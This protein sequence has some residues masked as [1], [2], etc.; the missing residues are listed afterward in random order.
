M[1]SLI[2]KAL[3]T[4]LLAFAVSVIAPSTASAD[5]N[6]FMFANDN[7]Y[8]GDRVIAGGGSWELTLF[9]Y[10]TPT[11]Y[12]VQNPGP[13]N[14][15]GNSNLGYCWGGYGAYS[16]HAVMQ[17]DGNFV[18]Y[19]GSTAIWSTGTH[20]WYGSYLN[21]Q[22]DSNIVVYTSWDYPLWSIW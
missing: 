8:C 1:C 22:D 17:G 18:A 15:C 5:Y 2:R 6:S 12:L 19:N 10:G 16:D 4:G 3:A 14:N 13:G 21:V 7:L 20:G 11:G 9:C